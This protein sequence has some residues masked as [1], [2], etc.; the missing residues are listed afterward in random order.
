MTLEM[1][2]AANTSGVPLV[3]NSTRNPPRAIPLNT[4]PFS[5]N[6]LFVWLRQLEELHETTM[7]PAIESVT[8]ER[9]RLYLREH[10]IVRSR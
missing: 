7:I 4:T 3:G 2:L 9:A 1:S 5:W 10:R 8:A 6:H